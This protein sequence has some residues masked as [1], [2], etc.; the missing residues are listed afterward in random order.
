MQDN[1]LFSDAFFVQPSL[2][3]RLLDELIAATKDFRK[4]PIG[5]IKSAFKSDGMGG[6]RRKAL[7]RF[8]L[9]IGV[10]FYAII[11][12]VIL[13]LWL[14]AHAHHKTQDDQ[15]TLVHMINPDDFKTQQIDM[16]KGDKKAGG[17]GGGGRNTP[18]PPSKG[19]L[20]QFSLKP[21][22]VAPRPE[23]QMTPPPLPVAE[24]VQVDPRL[25]PKRDD[26]TP[27][28]LPTG[29]P[30]PPSA[31][32]GSGGGMGAGS[33]GGMGT[34]SGTG[35]GPGHG[36]NMG[37][38]GPGLGGGNGPVANVDTLPMPL[39]RPRPNYT[40]EARKNKVQGVIRARALIGADGVVHDVRIITHLP[41]GLD[42]EA[43][44]AVYQMHF[45][46][47]TRAGQSVAHWVVLEVEFNLR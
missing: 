5:Y 2:W 32:P 14:I 10:T 26:L 40:E 29:V 11:F 8:G 23:P 12:G 19:Q 4:D 39:N 33:G 13:V 9:A 16:P 46:P 38:G 24:T 47:A 31:G 20:P 35:V 1:G 17:G 3:K 44:R 36:Y 27:T 45:R 21:P 41:D 18:T 22:I 6:N 25:Q 7:L 37:G 30:G 34:G 43:I 42:E 28:G 15:L